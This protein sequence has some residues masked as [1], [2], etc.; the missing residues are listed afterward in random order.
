MQGKKKK[1]RTVSLYC[2]IAVS[3]GLLHWRKQRAVSKAT[4][5]TSAG[6]PPTSKQQKLDFGAKQVSGGRVEEV[7][8]AVCCRGNAALKHG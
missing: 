6:G 2:D 3:Y 1:A 7:G 5:S 4:V 8:H